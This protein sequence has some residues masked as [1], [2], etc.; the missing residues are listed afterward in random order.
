M[1]DD[2]VTGRPACATCIHF[3]PPPKLGQLGHCR[4]H[5]PTLYVILQQNPLNPNEAQP[6]PT[7][8]WPPVG[9]GHHCGQHPDFAMWFGS[10]LTKQIRQA[11]AN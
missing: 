5:P 1:S 6:V 7:S 3:M 9:A 10:Y 8:F 11:A 4:A 2:R